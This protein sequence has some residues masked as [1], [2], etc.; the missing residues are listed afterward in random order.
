MVME[1]WGDHRNASRLWVSR[2]ISETNMGYIV[3]KLVSILIIIN[4]KIQ[5]KIC[6]FAI[7]PEMFQTSPKTSKKHQPQYFWRCL[8][9]GVRYPGFLIEWILLNWIKPNLNFWINFWIE[10]S[11]KNG[12]WITFLIEYS[13]KNWYWI[14]LWIEF[15]HE[16]NEWIIFWIDICHFWWKALFLVYFRY[17]LGNFW[18]LFPSDQYQWFPG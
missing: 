14:I 10:F 2:R 7:F 6:C 4:S 12:Y 3:W 1:Q 9:S 5:F 18:A 16:M 17:F 13:W 15:Y 8:T 11:R